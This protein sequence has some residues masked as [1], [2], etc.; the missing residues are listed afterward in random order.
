MAPAAW[1]TTTAGTTDQLHLLQARLVEPFYQEMLQDPV[2]PPPKNPER[3][4]NFLL[5]SSLAAVSFLLHKSRWLHHWAAWKDGMCGRIKEPSPRPLCHR[6]R[7]RGSGQL[8]YPPAK[9]FIIHFGLIPSKPCR[10]A[11]LWLTHLFSAFFGCLSRGKTRAWWV[12]WARIF[13]C[14]S[15][16][17]PD[18]AGPVKRIWPYLWWSQR[19]LVL[20]TQR[21][22]VFKATVKHNKSRD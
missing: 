18:L 1:S 3:H 2:K 6:P 21:T 7:C 8:H 22:P 17:S 11:Q 16:W 5:M 20:G 12:M 10:R 13:F 15:F 9:I 19:A 14:F 4:R